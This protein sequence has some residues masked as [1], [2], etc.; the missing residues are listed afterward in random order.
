MLI[1]YRTRRNLRRAFSVGAT[2]LLAVVLLLSCLLV[3]MQRFVVY[4][5][6][7]A[8]LDFDRA[9]GGQAKLPNDALQLPS[10]TINYSDSAYRE[11]LSY[12]SGYYIPESALKNPQS[13]LE[14][15]EALPA[16]TPV[17]IDLKAYRG[18]FFYS[19][20]VGAHTTGLYDI[21]KVDELI[22][23][24]TQ[25]E[26]YVIARVSSLRDFVTANENSAY[27]LKTASG[28]LYTDSGSYGIGHWLD[29]TNTSVQNYLISVVNE[30][31]N[32]GFDE[33]VLQNFR[34]PSTTDL[35]FA[36]DRQEAL[37]TCAEKIVAA[38]ADSAFAVSFCT[39]DAA[40]FTPPTNC[41]LYLEDISAEN[42]QDT[43]EQ[44]DIREKRRYL[45]FIAP[46]NDTRYD[47]ENGILRPLT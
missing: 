35:A 12:L 32:K 17:M 13:V 46:N 18:Y 16:G 41:R 14:K 44:A 5:R 4:T 22:R 37:E 30:L 19:T 23:Y 1:A 29:P 43:W 7:G 40:A 38:C 34:Y 36:G 45:V 10:V 42:A 27:G 3:W 31:K 9:A 28:A 24:L 21:T 20:S 6:E 47:I 8:V 2:V 26:L 25:S 15:L 33:V 39:D 11:G